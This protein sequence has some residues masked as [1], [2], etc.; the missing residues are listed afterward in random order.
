MPRTRIRSKES[1]PVNTPNRHQYRPGELIAAALDYAARGWH[2]LPLLPGTKRPAVPDHPAAACTRT[3]PAC[4]QGHAGWEQLATTDPAQIHTWWDDGGCGIGIATGPS[5]LVVI[6]LD[7][8]KPG[9]TDPRA[10]SA[11][12][13]DLATRAGER[14]V[15]TRTVATPSGGW[16]LYYT[17]PPGSALRCTA[18][19]LGPHIDTRAAGGYVVAPPTR[20]PAGTYR[21]VVEGDPEPLPEWLNQG[22]VATPRQLRPAPAQQVLTLT[23]TGRLARYVA[24]AIEAETGRVTAARRH[25]RNKTLLTAAIALGQLVGAGVLDTDTATDALARAADFHVNHDAAIGAPD[26]FTRAEA[27]TTIAS[28]LRRGIAEPRRL[29]DHF[30][31]VAS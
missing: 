2:V 6:D 23:P 22:L 13:D 18:G 14:L 10:G 1:A 21:T 5:R 31:G 9:D 12:L 27:R 11:V 24:T 19:Q 29:P 16:H 20:T 4:R 25:H 17:P 3:A 8:A 15:H 28:G 30:R 26:P 7:T